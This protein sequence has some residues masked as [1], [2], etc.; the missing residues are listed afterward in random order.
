MTDPT[1]PWLQ[2]LDEWLAEPDPAIPWLIPRFLPATSKVIIS[3]QAKKAQK[4]YFAFAMGISIVTGKG[5]FKVD[6]RVVGQ[7]FLAIEE[8]GQL[9]ETKQRFRAL[10]RAYE[11]DEGEL[12]PF[13]ISFYQGVRL[14]EPQWAKR[15]LE[16]VGDLKPV[17]VVLD[18][19]YKLHGAEENSNREIAAVLRTIDDIKRLGSTPIFIHHLEKARGERR[20]ADL[21]SQIRGAGNLSGDYDHHLALRRYT[22]EDTDIDLTVL[23]KGAAP[24]QYS[25]KWDFEN[26]LVAPGESVVWRARLGLRSTDAPVNAPVDDATKKRL[27]RAIKALKPGREYGFMDLAK[28]WRTSSS[29]A[30]TTELLDWLREEGVLEPGSIENHYVCM[31]TKEKT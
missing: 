1:H 4:S 15:V 2:P 5:P 24:S 25:V 3:G 19:F 12:N 22:W 11:I 27:E 23:S 30:K 7:P 17:A 28:L 10:A 13:R 31:E 16:A 20:G 26:H 29:V 14:D 9:S 8:E 6:E 18:P 21:D